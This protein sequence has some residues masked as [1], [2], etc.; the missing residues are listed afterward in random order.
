MP[1]RPE[2]IFVLFEKNKFEISNTGRSLE[3]AKNE[4][5]TNTGHFPKTALCKNFYS[6]F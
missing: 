5:V 4:C 3:F 2:Y 1:Q 6:T